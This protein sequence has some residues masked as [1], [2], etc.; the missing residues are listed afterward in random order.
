MPLPK[1]GE[2]L[3]IYGV[4]GEQ[5]AKVET[6]YHWKGFPDEDYFYVTGFFSKFFLRLENA[7]D[8]GWR[9]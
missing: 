7:L 2:E 1:L 4:W 3:V 8:W 5:L 9:R 6:I